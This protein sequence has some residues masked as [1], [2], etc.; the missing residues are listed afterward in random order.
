MSCVLMDSPRIDMLII[1]LRRKILIN[2]WIIIYPFDTFDNSFTWK[3][4]DDDKFC[5]ILRG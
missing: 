2:G 1:S 4:I 3:R 5:S